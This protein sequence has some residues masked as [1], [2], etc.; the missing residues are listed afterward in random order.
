MNVYDFDKTIYDGDSTLDFYLYCLRKHPYL[1]FYIPMQL[2]YVILY[3]F[4]KYK[5]T[6]FKEHFYTFLNKLKD[7]DNDINNFWNINQKKI[8][9]FYKN[10]K[11]S[12]DVV[13]SASPEFLLQPICSKLGINSLIASK[14]DK[15][16]GKYTGINCH[17]EEKV[18]RFY[19]IYPDQEIDKFYSDSLSDKPLASIAKKAYI[20]HKEQI[21]KWN[22]YKPSTLDK[23]KKMFLSKSFILFIFVGCINTFNGILFSYL[24][25]LIISN[26]N[27]AFV[28]GYI[29]SL[30]VSY[31]LNSFITFKEKLEFNKYIKFCISYIPNFIIQNIIVFIVYN[32]LNWNK[33]IAYALAAIIG[34]PVTF[35]LM[36]IFAFKKK[37]SI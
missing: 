16:T 4:G 36:N 3:M 8:K 11:N 19:K 18:K 23:L 5:K 12:S 28:F 6:Q 34:L 13:I 30:T 15:H 10:Q 33:L 37:K 9:L 31:L 22:E 25:S 29:T 35:L 20:V 21:L 7:V 17:G 27:L 1:L 2:V 14:V 26:A 32:T 24:Y